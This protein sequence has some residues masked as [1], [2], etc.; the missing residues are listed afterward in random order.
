MCAGGRASACVCAG[1]RE[2][3]CVCMTFWELIDGLGN[4]SHLRTIFKDS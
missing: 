2:R 1:A 3:M 4:P